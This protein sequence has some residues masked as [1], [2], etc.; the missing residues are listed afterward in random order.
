M[1]GR[2]VQCNCIACH[3][4][5]QNVLLKHKTVITSLQH[6]LHL[7]PPVIL[8]YHACHIMADCDKLLSQLSIQLDITE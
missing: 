8:Q 3:L 6:T 2:T 7:L 4:Q 5:M 1:S